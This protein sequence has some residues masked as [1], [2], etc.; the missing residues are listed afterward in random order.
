[1]DSVLEVV[2]ELILE[3]VLDS[4]L[5]VILE[6]ALEVILGALPDLTELCQHLIP[7]D[8]SQQEETD[9]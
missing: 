6:A 9:Q 7:K 5:E 4:T 3:V 2:L 1:M 8:A